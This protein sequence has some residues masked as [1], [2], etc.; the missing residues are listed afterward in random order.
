MSPGGCDWSSK[1]AYADS[2]VALRPALLAAIARGSATLNNLESFDY[3]AGQH[4]YSRSIAKFTCDWS[5]YNGVIAAVQKITDPAQRQ[6]AARA[7]GV[8]ARVSLIANATDMVQ[9][10]LATVS[11]IE[12]SGTVMNVITHGAWGAIGPAPTAALAA[13]TGEPL[14]PDAQPPTGYD[15]LR[16]PQARVQV[17]R[18]MLA[19][20]EPLRVRAIVLAAPAQA[21]T[22][23]TLFSALLGSSSWAATP[24]AQA[25]PEAGLERFVFTGALPAQPADFQ[26]Y[27]RADLPPNATA[28]MRG[29]G[30]PAGTVVSPAGVQ[31]FVPPG[32]PGAPHTVVIVPA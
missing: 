3:W 19:A 15:A 29:L 1:Y 17:M 21:P 27:L 11:T 18:S 23:V 28:Y 13:L 5:A 26:W 2:L 32:G 10:L 24:L 7:Q 20:G 14:P 9:S 4:V 12:G 8:A 25:A 6:A 22:A 16:A 30:V 31:C